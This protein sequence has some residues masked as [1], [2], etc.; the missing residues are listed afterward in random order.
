MRVLILC[1]YS[2]L[3]FRQFIP[4]AINDSTVINVMIPRE[5]TQ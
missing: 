1:S 5:I 3:C 2:S 4:S